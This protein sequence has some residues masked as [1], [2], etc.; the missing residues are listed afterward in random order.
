MSDLD[1]ELDKINENSTSE[2]KDAVKQG[3][4]Q[5]ILSEEMQSRIEDMF[6]FEDEEI[7]HS[8]V[9]DNRRELDGGPT[10]EQ[11]K[12][13][14]SY[15]TGNAGRPIFVEKLTANDSQR[16]KDMSTVTAMYGI[17]ML[18]VM[19]SYNNMIM[20]ELYKPERIINMETKDLI[21]LSSGLLK[22]IQLLQQNASQTIQ[23]TGYGENSEA[24]KMVD[25]ITSMSNEKYA[26]T[27]EILSLEDG[28][29]LLVRVTE[30]IKNKDNDPQTYERLKTLLNN[31]DL[32]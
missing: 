22:N 10:I 25:L 8:D 12:E 4:E 7:P 23:A 20:E 26:R 5:E 27:R 9:V 28:D 30:V 32:I 13:M 17:G 6:N 14:T 24:R 11:L 31:E 18:P 21:N 3:I 2:V 16:L 15:L 19:Y 29:N 1:K